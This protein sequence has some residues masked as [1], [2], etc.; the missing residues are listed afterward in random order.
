MAAPVNL[1]LYRGNGDNMII[2]IAASIV[3]IACST[4]AV[5]QT[6]MGLFPNRFMCLDLLQLERLEVDPDGT[7][8]LPTP[9]K[10]SNLLQITTKQS[11]GSK[12]T[13]PLI[14]IVQMAT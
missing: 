1:L 14:M 3:L 2:R 12:D 9:N 6:P 8:N 11:V 7:M 5:A 13:S 10:T 4:H